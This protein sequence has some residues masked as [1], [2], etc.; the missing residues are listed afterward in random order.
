MKKILL[1]FALVSGLVFPSAA[2]QPA[3]TCLFGSDYNKGNSSY[4][5][6]W[7]TTNNGFTWSVYAFNNNNNG[8]TGAIKCG[9]KNN[10]SV[11]TITTSTSMPEAIEKVI[12]Y[13]DDISVSNVNSITFKISASDDFITSDNIN[14]PVEKGNKT[15]EIPSPKPNR[16]YRFEFDCKKSSSNGTV[17]ISKIEYY[18][19]EDPDAKTWAKLS[20][21]ETNFN[22]ILGDDFT[23][24]QLTVEPMEAAEFVTY[25]SSDQSIAK[26]DNSG[27]VEIIGEG[28]V[29]ITASI[30]ENDDY[31]GDAASY[32]INI[33]HP[34]AVKTYQLLTDIDQLGDS[35]ECLIVNID[36]FMALSTTQTKN[37]RSATLVPIQ[38]N[39]IINP[40]NEVEII[41]IEKLDNGYY[42]LLALS[43]ESGGYLYASGAN[44]SNSLG[45]DQELNSNGNSYAEIKVTEQNTS[46]IFKGTASRNELRF[47]LNNGSPLFSCYASNNSQ[48]DV[49][50]F[51]NPE[52]VIREEEPDTDITIVAE[53]WIQPW[54]EINGLEFV[55]EVPEHIDEIFEDLIEFEI[56]PLFDTDF[57]DEGMSTDD[58]KEMA[59]LTTARGHNVDGLF[60]GIDYE[61][62]IFE[63][64]YLMA[65]FPCSGQYEIW[66]KSLDPEKYTVNGE[67]ETLVGTAHLYPSATNSFKVGEVEDDNQEMVIVEQMFNVNGIS[68]KEGDGGYVIEYPYVK[69]END[70]QVIFAK[71]DLKTANLFVPG[72]YLAKLYY[73]ITSVSGPESDKKD[74]EPEL[75]RRRIAGSLTTEKDLVDAEYIEYLVDVP[76]THPDLSG[77]ENGETFKVNVAL[78]KNGLSTPLIGDT[79]ESEQNFTISASPEYAIPV[80]VETIGQEAEETEAIYFNLQGVRVNNPERGLYIKV[81]GTKATKVVKN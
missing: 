80:G 23:A 77:L 21:S 9:N 79:N 11:A 29:T 65:E 16:Y 63:D 34:S 52:T 7:T 78:V 14:I 68:G 48:L 1:L 18:A 64:T 25:S 49:A 13:L 46:I 20:F 19:E 45:T 53:D 2:Q 26:V 30:E 36:N 31:E 69:D 35:A 10:A 50:I 55:A 81:V 56:K 62:V 22:I 75:I 33:T 74:N 43:S 32:K 24:P 41:K 72:V 39:Q 59:Y 44:S 4:S 27:N 58:R 67:P 66:A 15:I 70:E 38:D 61:N 17:Q 28:E 42:S 8:W 5:D 3:Y 6:T 54:E 12:L 76:S 73:R 40:I 60:T 51:Y 71:D 57:T 47:N 37:N